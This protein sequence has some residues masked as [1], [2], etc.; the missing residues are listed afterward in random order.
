MGNRRLSHFEKKKR[1]HYAGSENRGHP[2]FTWMV[3][4]LRFPPTFDGSEPK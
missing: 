1:R 4:Q 2:F 3:G